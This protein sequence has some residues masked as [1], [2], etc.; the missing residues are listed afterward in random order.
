MSDL[1]EVVSNWKVT[2]EKKHNFLE[3]LKNCIEGCKRCELHKDE[4]KSVF[5]EG[6]IDADLM[7]VAE[8]PGSAESETGRP[9]VGRAGQLLTK[10]IGAMDMKRDE[11]YIANTVKHRPPDNR[12]PKSEEIY[13][14]LPYLFSQ[15]ATINP[16][17]IVTLGN[18]ATKTLLNTNTGITTLRGKIYQCFYIMIP[19][20]PTFHPAYLLRDSR[21]KKESWEDLKLIRDLLRGKEFKLSRVQRG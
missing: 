3:S 11:V 5:G 18:P 1:A 16:K 14:C 2:Q 9:F 7:F 13:A 12:D 15:I 4:G 8:G 17:F 21:K 10:M 20:I 6:N 19:V